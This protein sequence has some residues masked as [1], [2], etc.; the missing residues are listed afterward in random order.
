MKIIVGKKY[1]NI[2]SKNMVVTV[3]YKALCWIFFED[4][5]GKWAINNDRAPW[6]IHYK[7]FQKNYVLIEE[8]DH[9]KPA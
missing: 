3:V 2:H 1:K 8:A 9:E 7:T 5:Q 4:F 6:R